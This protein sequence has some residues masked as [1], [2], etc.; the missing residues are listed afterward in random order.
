MYKRILTLSLAFILLAGCKTSRIAQQDTHSID[1]NYPV[2]DYAIQSLLWQ[3]TSGEYKALAYQAYNLARMELD[4]IIKNTDKRSKPLAV[5][6][7][8]DETV[9]DNSPYAGKQLEL[10]ED[11]NKE[12]WIEW[13]EQV[14]AQPVPGS[15]EFFTYAKQHGVEMF[16]ISNRYDQQKHETIA[17]LK[18]FGYPFTD[19]AH[20]LLRT[21]TGSKK[22]R[23]EQ[24]SKTHNIVMLL[25]DNLSD[26]STV[27]ENKSTNERNAEVN[28]LKA[29]FGTKFI[30]LPN[31]T[32]GDWENKGIFEGRY[33]WTPQ[34]RDSI[35]RKKVISY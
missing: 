27:F 7:D 9:L 13:G 16:Y 11:Y 34:Q 32:Y 5:V 33:D 14:A 31:P 21:T 3:Q 6:T 10:N 28:A 15:V 18:K 20:V 25:G 22:E 17:N 4:E 24:V 19:E 8:I 1:A 12:R 26:F 2:R 30:V 29:D 35:M 23:R